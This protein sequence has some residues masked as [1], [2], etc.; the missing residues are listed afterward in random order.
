M[1]TPEEYT[2]YVGLSQPKPDIVQSANHSQPISRGGPEIGSLDK[3]RDILFGN[4]MQ[5]RDQR[6]A[7]LEEHLLR[8]YTS[9]QEETRKRL[10]SLEAY[11]QK[12][13]NSLIE[14]LKKDQ[15]EREETQKQLAQELKELIQSWES[16]ITQVNEQ[17][18][19]ME[20]DTH[21]QILSLSKSLSEQMQQKTQEILAIEQK[22]QELRTNKTDYSTL[23]AIF[24][25]LAARLN[26]ESN[27]D[28]NQ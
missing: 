28:D 4:Q 20:R 2:K 6:L 24:A 12:E 10:D 25:E 22:N 18:N 13:V 9:F 16:K 27:I 1:S 23:A 11:I 5:E 19:A 8:E 15:A 21:Q 3:I 14:Q 26:N 17:T 7:R